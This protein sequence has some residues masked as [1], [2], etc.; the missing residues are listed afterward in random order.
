MCIL[1]LVAGS[2]ATTVGALI[3]TQGLMYDMGFLAFYC[4]MLSMVNK[5]WIMRRGMVYGLFRSASGVFGIVM[6]F[7]IKA[8]VQK[9]DY[10][11]TLRAI[12]TASFALT[13]PLIPL[14]KGWLCQTFLLFS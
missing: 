3:F 2:F 6:L 13:G 8:L 9:Y 14:Q 7:V 5:F 11:V 4:S 12:A 10:L 1:N